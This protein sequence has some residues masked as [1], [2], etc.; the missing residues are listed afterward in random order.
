M[1]VLLSLLSFATAFCIGKQKT[2]L[3]GSLDAFQR[4]PCHN[5]WLWGLGFSAHRVLLLW[6][7]GVGLT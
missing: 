6:V 5:L 1:F 2:F 3:F 4:H 7:Q